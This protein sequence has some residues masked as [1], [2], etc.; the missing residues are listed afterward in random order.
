MIAWTEKFY[1][2]ANNLKCIGIWIFILIHIIQYPRETVV[3]APL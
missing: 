1:Y 2:D 3:A